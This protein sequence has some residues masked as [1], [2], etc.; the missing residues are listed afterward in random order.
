MALCLWPSSQKYSLKQEDKR[1]MLSVL[2]RLMLHKF[3]NVAF[4]SQHPRDNGT[5]EQRGT[6]GFVCKLPNSQ[7]TSSLSDNCLGS[8]L[9]FPLPLA[10][11]E[12]EKSYVS[13]PYYCFMSQLLTH[14]LDNCQVRSPQKELFVSPRHQKPPH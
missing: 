1:V 5:G 8:I 2:S 3:N 12:R 14:F 11:K 4:H 9:F 6:E 13:R 7:E 10:L